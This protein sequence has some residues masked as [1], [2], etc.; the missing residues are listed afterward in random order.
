MRRRAGAAG[1][2]GA[3]GL[4]VEAEAAAEARDVDALMDL[5][6]DDY[7]GPRGEPKSAV[8]PLARFALGRHQTVHLLTRISEID[9]RD[10]T[11]ARATVFVAMGG[12]PI[13]G[14]EELES[15]R[16]SLWRFDVLIHRDGG[17]AQVTQAQWRRA[18]P[19]DFF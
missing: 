2:A 19:D 3:H 4:V 9:V 12:R 7:R 11:Q 17:D 6:A 18:R 10:S 14:P 8:A 13:Q 5:V 15:L 16:G 1:S